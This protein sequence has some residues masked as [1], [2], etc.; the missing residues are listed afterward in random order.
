MI[1]STFLDPIST[2]ILQGECR[3][4]LISGFIPESSEIYH[5]LIDQLDW[6]QDQ[7]TLYGKTHDV[8]RLQAWYADA[9]L[10]YTYSHIKLEPTPWNE[11]LLDLKKRIEDSCQAEFNSVLCNY[12]RHG[13][14]YVAWHSDNE[15]ELGQE[16]VIASLSFGATRKFVLRE[17]RD[18]KKKIELNLKS[19]DLLLMSGKTQ[20]LYEHQI[21]KT[22]KEK[23]GR[24]NLTF[25]QV[26]RS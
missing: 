13:S 22:K 1:Q 3:V 9:G 25:R 6:R 24:V 19:G 23:E 2:M 16:P 10:T 7:I 21:S 18:K 5:N 17:K 15:P 4:E 8:P 12:Y 14:D 26:I 11:L 20:E